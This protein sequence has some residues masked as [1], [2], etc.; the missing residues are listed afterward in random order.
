H[1]APAQAGAVPA[2]DTLPQHA[3]LP[4]SLVSGPAHG[5]LTLNA[6]GSFTY[7]PNANYYGPDSFTYRANDGSLN[8]NVA[9]VSITVNAVN[10]APVAVNDAYSLSEDQTL[11]V[12][13]TPRV[14]SLTMVSQPGDYIGQGQTYSYTPSTGT[15]MVHRNFDNGV[16]ISYSDSIHWWYLDF[17]APFD[18]T[19][20]P[21]TY[22]NAT[23]W[24]FQASN[25]PG[26]SVSGD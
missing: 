23:R 11:T 7:T 25:V 9:T 12:T 19:L 24:P 17:A 1:E 13:P 21:G 26:L 10:D 6:G 20:T 18:A 2:N 8:S 15:F 16:S 4:A 5:S 3:A 14:T 22:L